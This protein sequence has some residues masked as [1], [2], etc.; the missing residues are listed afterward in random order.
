MCPKEMDDSA[1]PEKI[2][3]KLLMPSCMR[4]KME[5]QTDRG[6]TICPFPSF[7]KCGGVGGGG[8]GG[9]HKKKKKKK[10]KNKQASHPIILNE[11][12]TFV[13][14]VLQYSLPV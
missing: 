1:P 13:S 4:M 14:F 9:G 11:V 6:N 8:G 3:H 7:F 10:T 2:K 12:L 5:G